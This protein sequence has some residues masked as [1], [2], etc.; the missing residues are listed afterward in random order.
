[1]QRP[2]WT[3]RVHGVRTAGIAA[4][5]ALTACLALVGCGAPVGSQSSRSGAA[6][7]AT[8]TSTTSSGPTTTATSSG[9]TA[10]TIPATPEDLCAA[11][12]PHRTLIAW[13]A[14]R[15]GDF[16]AYNYGPPG[17]KPPL[18][19]AF[20]GVADQVIGAWC[21]TR[22]GMTSI[23][24]AVVWQRKPQRA[25]TL[26]GPGGDVHREWVDGPPQVP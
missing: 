16:R 1:M 20:P 25:I 22:S 17:H 21:A 13:G 23:W 8:P 19:K 7:S 14:G 24:W 11:A 12:L 5:I 2:A 15:V 10:S 18:A 9:P 3:V 26:V 4:G 6:T